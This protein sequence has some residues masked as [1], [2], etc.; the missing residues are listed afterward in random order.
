MAMY[1][2]YVV[3]RSRLMV[4]FMSE[5]ATAGR[6]TNIVVAVGLRSTTT[7]T[8]DVTQFIEMGRG[9]WSVVGSQ[10]G[11]ATATLTL[12]CDVGAYL[13]RSNVMADPELKGSNASDPTEEVFFELNVANL[14][15]GDPPGLDCLVVI[16]Y[17]ASFI[18]AKRL[19]QS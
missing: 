8:T 19:V 14:D 6:D 13:G 9:E 12:A 7:S 2:H 10:N 3:H 11:K 1:D 18:E 15:G 16:E 5:S 4:T 17:D